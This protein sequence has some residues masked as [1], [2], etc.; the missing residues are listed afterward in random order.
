MNQE[1][2]RELGFQN[3]VEKLHSSQ[4][5]T[6]WW[7]SENETESVYGELAESQMVQNN[8]EKKDRAMNDIIERTKNS[9]IDEMI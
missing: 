8:L 6:K 1:A 9:V 2:I 3:E 4:Q 7:N 5:K